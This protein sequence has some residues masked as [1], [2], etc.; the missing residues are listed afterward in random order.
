MKKLSGKKDEEGGG[1]ALLTSPLFPRK[2]RKEFDDVLMQE[3]K[4]SS[5]EIYG[6]E[7]RGLLWL[8]ASTYPHIPTHPYSHPILKSHPAP[9]RK[10][11]KKMRGAS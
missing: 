11:P 7:K 4:I 1:E 5:G 8:W 3:K 2:K 6:S 9:L 10:A